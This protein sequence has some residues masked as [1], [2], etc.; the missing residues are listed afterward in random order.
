[1]AS[2]DAI[3]G[4]N[5]PLALFSMIHPES[6]WNMDAVLSQWELEGHISDEITTI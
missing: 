5:I 3:L 4:R 1:M 6:L 2:N